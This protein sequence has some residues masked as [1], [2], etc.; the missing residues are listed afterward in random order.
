MK[1]SIWT[2][3]ATDKLTIADLQQEFP[4]YVVVGFSINDGMLSACFQN[5]DPMYS[6][7]WR[8]LGRIQVTQAAFIAAFL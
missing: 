3:A 1:E 7:W 5:E 4:Q 2:K 8:E 6:N